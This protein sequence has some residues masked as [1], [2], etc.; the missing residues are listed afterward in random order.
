MWS[1]AGLFAKPHTPR[2]R[3]VR[4]AIGACGAHVADLGSNER[5]DRCHTARTPGHQP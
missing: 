2:A 3:C 1:R 4:H 5:Q